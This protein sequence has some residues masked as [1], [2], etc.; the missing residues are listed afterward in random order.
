VT[1]GRVRASWW[2]VGVLA[3]AV[4]ATVVVGGQVAVTAAFDLRAQSRQ[5][6]R[7]HRLHDAGSTAFRVDPSQAALV[8]LSTRD[9]WCSAKRQ[10]RAAHLRAIVLAAAALLVVHAMLALWAIALRGGR[11]W[12][13]RREAPATPA[14][15]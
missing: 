3:V 15:A 10:T 11:I 6:A 1:A 7:V 2:T 4:L 13:P 14:R 9:A 8:T 12:M 5:I